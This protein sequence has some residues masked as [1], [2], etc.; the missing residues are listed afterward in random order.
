MSLLTER[1]AHQPPTWASAFKHFYGEE[2]KTQVGL[3]EPV[4]PQ[5]REGKFNSVSQTGNLRPIEAKNHTR[6][7]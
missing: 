7:G 4:S 5:Q 1:A 2:N 6:E 3:E